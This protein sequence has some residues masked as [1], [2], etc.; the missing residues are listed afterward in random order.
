ML[1]KKNNNI[2]NNDRTLTV[3]YDLNNKNNTKFNHKIECTMEIK[4]NNNE[5]RFKMKKP[6]N[7]NINNTTEPIA[8]LSMINIISKYNDLINTCKNDTNDII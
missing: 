3:K 2:D 1:T 6:M 7:L 5:F 8:S 4:S